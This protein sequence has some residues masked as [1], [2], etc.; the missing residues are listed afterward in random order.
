M[1]P[2]LT[3]A[4]TVDM[5]REA[6]RASR[7]VVGSLHGIGHRAQDEGAHAGGAGAA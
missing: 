2:V 3:V 6:A 7:P 4:L 5:T 1:R